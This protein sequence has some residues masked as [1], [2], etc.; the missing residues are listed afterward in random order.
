MSSNDF[1]APDPLSRDTGQVPEHPEHAPAAPAVPPPAPS[2]VSSG[3]GTARTD[4]SSFSRGTGNDE[5][6]NGEN[7]DQARSL[8][9]DGQDATKQV[10]ETARREASH[11]VED[12]KEEASNLFEE[13]GA[14]VRAQAAIQQDKIATNLREI[15]QELRGM[16]ESSSSGS[17]ASLLVDQAARHSGKVAQWLENR[18]PGDLVHEVKDFAR[19]RPG[20][21][22]G[23]AL[24]A[25]LLAGRI[26]RNATAKP[27]DTV[28]PSPVSPEPP[29]A[30]APRTV[31]TMPPTYNDT[32]GAGGAGGSGI[33]PGIDYP[34]PTVTGPGPSQGYAGS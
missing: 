15:S 5:E 7:T 8:V 14:D 2:P 21:F 26:T 1:N 10:G 11:V 20:A 24:G 3:L 12:V 23:L 27:A 31:E 33:D 19:K 34:W 30:G 13:L 6:N 29:N 32:I 22:L 25:G 28:N 17:S 16:L 18:E 9:E 4:S